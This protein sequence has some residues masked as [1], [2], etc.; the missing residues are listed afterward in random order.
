MFNLT[1]LSWFNS[2][3]LI[4]LNSSD[5]IW[6]NLPIWFNYNYNYLTHYFKF[7]SVFKKFKLSFFIQFN[8]S[9]L[10][11]L[12]QISYLIRYKLHSFYS[13]VLIEISYVDSIWLSIYDSIWIIIYNSIWPSFLIWFDK[14]FNPSTHH[15]RFG[16]DFMIQSYS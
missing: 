12:T 6:L 16:S 3:F 1:C 5:S 4:W 8:V 9:F 13:P 15:F 2:I 14:N 10:F 11:N 7:D